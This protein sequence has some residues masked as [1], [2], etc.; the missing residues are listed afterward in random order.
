M[1]NLPTALTTMVSY[2]TGTGTGTGVCWWVPVHC[3]P[4][5]AT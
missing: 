1:N 5:G 2:G 3:D 4:S